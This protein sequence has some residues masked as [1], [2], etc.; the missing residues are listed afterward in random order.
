MTEALLQSITLRKLRIFAAIGRLIS[1]A[2]AGS[3]DFDD[4]WEEA[5]SAWRIEWRNTM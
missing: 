5:P 1:A 2:K 3:T 4:Y